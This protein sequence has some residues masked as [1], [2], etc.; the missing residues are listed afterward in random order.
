MRIV[1]KIGTNLL[2]TREGALDTA[3]I[4]LFAE[5][6]AGLRKKGHQVV[7]VSSGA[8][9][10]GMGKL[11]L[12]SRPSSLRDKQ[13]LA[14]VGQPL[15]MNAYEHSFGGRG[16]AVAQVLLTRQDFDDRQR[17]LNARNTLLALLEFG[18]IPVINENDT[19]AVEE[20]NFGDNDTLAA[21][22]AAKIAAD[23]LFLLTDVDGFY[24]GLPGKG[25]LI[26][27]VEKIT[28]EIEECASCVSG[29]GK[30]TGGMRTKLAAGKIAAMAGVKMVIASGR[31]QRAVTRVLEGE[32]VG[33]LF[34]PGQHIEP[35][36]CWIAFGTKCRG[37]I[38]V[39]A[40]AAEALLKRGKSLLPSGIVA[41]EKTFGVGDTV[42][43]V[44]RAG[45]EIGRGL[46]YYSS[47]DV[48]RIKGKKTAEIKKILE[49]TD[50]EEVV[51]RDNLVI[52]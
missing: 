33:T 37:K 44:D 50:I 11:G 31:E 28:P 21:M 51:H 5:E 24:R 43:I 13:A 35:R 10:A 8:I 46:T 20:I 14:A 7:I 6:L 34:L 48:D 3:R 2:T 49:H 52:L 42:S 26:R 18:V 16:C 41:T 39:D 4:G 47:A 1:I 29:S 12:A 25:E 32:A 19:V 22:V 38:V 36:K 17:Y 45:R 27:V 40:G 9:G 30:G 23:W 15:L